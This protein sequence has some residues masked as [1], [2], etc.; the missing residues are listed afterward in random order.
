MWF[1]I[2][3]AD[4]YQMILDETD[5]VL[6]DLRDPDSYAEDHIGPA[7]NIFSEEL[8]VRYREL[9]ADRLIVLYCYRGPNA[10]LAAR[11]LSKAGYRVANVCGGFC[12]YRAKYQG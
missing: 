11:D 7:I 8:P 5:M 12:T 6:V 9:P 3:A 1:I 10:M 2:S 4:L